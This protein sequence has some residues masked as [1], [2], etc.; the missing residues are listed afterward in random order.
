ML[1]STGA[2]CCFSGLRD[3]T[4]RLVLFLVFLYFGFWDVFGCDV[5]HF[6]TLALIPIDVYVGGVSE[7]N[8][9]QIKPNKMKR[10]K[11]GKDEEY[12]QTS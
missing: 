11:D 5:G 10:E 8:Q 2:P 12:H 7:P 4:Y 6:K 1:L 9:T 3:W